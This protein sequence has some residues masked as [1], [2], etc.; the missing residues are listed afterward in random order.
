MNTAEPCHFTR[1]TV[2]PFPNALMKSVKVQIEAH[3]K[4]H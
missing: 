3:G 1:R 4:T 2:I